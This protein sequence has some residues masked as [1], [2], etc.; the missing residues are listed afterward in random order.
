M[1]FRLT[2]LTAIAMLL[3]SGAAFAS[4][5]VSF[6][7][8][9]VPVLRTECAV[10]HLTGN[11]AGNI[12]LAPKVAYANLVGVPSKESTMLRV[13]AGS[14][15]ESYLVHKLDGTHLN[16]GGKGSQ[17]PFGAEPLDPAIRAKI[18]AWIKAGA[19]NN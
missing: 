5:P 2:V 18:R 8:D 16:V 13:K 11:E 6:A 14:P 17:M 15:D 19:P 10:C 7:K 3:P 9:I 1:I 12:A 4:E